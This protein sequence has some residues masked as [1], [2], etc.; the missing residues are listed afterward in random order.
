MSAL[1]EAMAAR[2]AARLAAV[3]ALYQLEVGGGTPERMTEELRAGRLPMG[4]LGPLDGAEPDAGLFEKI[5]TVTVENQEGVDRTV[6][7]HLGE[8]WRLERIDSVARAILRAGV[9][10]L[11]AKRETPSA[12]IVDEYVEIAKAFFDAA[13]PGFVNAALEACARDVRGTDAFAPLG[14]DERG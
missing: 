10:E 5:V 12:V 3:Q 11:W 7:R 6:A 13:E 4:E 8:K 2:R 14:G 9:A 1:P